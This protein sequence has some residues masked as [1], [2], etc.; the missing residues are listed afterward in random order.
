MYSQCKNCFSDAN[1]GYDPRNPIITSRGLK[2]AFTFTNKLH[3]VSKGF[4]L[5]RYLNNLKRKTN[6]VAF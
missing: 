1:N 4:C 3:W 6:K 5:I 2:V